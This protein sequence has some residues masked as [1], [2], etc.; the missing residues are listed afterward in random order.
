MASSKGLTLA[1]NIASYQPF[2][3]LHYTVLAFLLAALTSFIPRDSLLLRRGI[4]LLHITCVAVHGQL[5][6]SQITII[7]IVR[8]NIRDT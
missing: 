3:N 7:R 4:L 6:E 2:N 8:Q 5:G 1:A